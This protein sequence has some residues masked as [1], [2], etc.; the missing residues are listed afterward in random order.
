MGYNVSSAFNVAEGG[1]NQL[2]PV[3][4]INSVEIIAS[5]GLQGTV[6]TSDERPLFF[7]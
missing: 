1:L 6:Y 5:N 3:Q 2:F 7:F 4:T